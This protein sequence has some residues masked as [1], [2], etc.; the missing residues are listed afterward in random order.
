MRLRQTVWNT[1]VATASYDADNNP[2]TAPVV[3]SVTDSTVV[4]A[5]PPTAPVA[6]LALTSDTGTVGDGITQDTTPTLS[7]GGASP[8]DTIKLNAPDGT[9]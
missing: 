1:I 6:S 4:D 3:R 9:T 5:T 7:G 8:G 2:A